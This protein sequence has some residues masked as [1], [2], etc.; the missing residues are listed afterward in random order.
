[1]ASFWWANG[2]V[3]GSTISFWS[4]A[5]FT[6]RGGRSC[7]LAAE[8]LYF[9]VLKPYLAPSSSNQP[10]LDYFA[11]WPRHHRQNRA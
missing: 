6:T 5:T 4:R 3:V 8:N 10:P 9:W 11:P 7:S 1:M 2:S